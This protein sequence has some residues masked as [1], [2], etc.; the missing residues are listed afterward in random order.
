MKLTKKYTNVFTKDGY[1][2]ITMLELDW[3]QDVIFERGDLNDGYS[4]IIDHFKN[5]ERHWYE[6]LMDCLLDVKEFTK[7]EVN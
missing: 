5:K 1:G 4:S 3:G 6:S 7:I 2:G